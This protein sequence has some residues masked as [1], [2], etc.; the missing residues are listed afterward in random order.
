MLD[1]VWKVDF[2][3]DVYAYTYVYTQSIR[4]F[5][6]K[7]DEMSVNLQNNWAIL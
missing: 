2:D 7:W 6:S 5:G 3:I 1:T 4:Y